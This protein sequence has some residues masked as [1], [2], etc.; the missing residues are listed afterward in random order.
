MRFS[1]QTHRCHPL[2]GLILGSHI[3]VLAYYRKHNRLHHQ[4]LLAYIQLWMVSGFPSQRIPIQLPE[5][6]IQFSNII[7]QQSL[8]NLLRV[9]DLTQPS[10]ILPISPRPIS[11]VAQIDTDCTVS[12]GI[13]TYYRSLLIY[14]A[15]H[16]WCN[17]HTLI[18]IP[19]VLRVHA[20]LILINLMVLCK[21]GELT[22]PNEAF[23]SQ[24]AKLWAIMILSW[25][26][27]R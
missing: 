24:F 14:K 26:D 9:F 8:I 17:P 19:I 7:D 1:N 23:C 12:V 25:R 21:V 5:L 15:K 2:S 20:S 10:I 3:T 4:G 18:L 16:K 11:I 6:V 27:N 13:S 22:I